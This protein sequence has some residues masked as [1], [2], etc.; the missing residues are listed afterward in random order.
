MGLKLLAHQGR[1]V[2]CGDYAVRRVA[3]GY[4]DLSLTVSHTMRLEAYD[5]AVR[6]IGAQQSLKVMFEFDERDW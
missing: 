1:D 5:K 2:A 6:M 4:I 3:G